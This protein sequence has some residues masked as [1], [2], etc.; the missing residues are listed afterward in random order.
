MTTEELDD[1]MKA[2]P[3]SSR[4]VPPITPKLGFKYFDEKL[5][6]APSRKRE[7]TKNE[8]CNTILPVLE[9]PMSHPEHERWPSLDTPMQQ[10]VDTNFHASCEIQNVQCA[11]IC[12]S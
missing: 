1:E 11:A 10:S 12:G 6:Y 8:L 7:K 5:Y 4:P 2:G 9:S 3:S